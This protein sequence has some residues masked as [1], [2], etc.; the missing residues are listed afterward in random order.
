MVISPADLRARLHGVIAFP[1][2]PFGAD[3]SLDIAGLR[4]NLQHLLAHPI[5]AVVAAVL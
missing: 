2:T 5:C 3:R 4:A 1:V